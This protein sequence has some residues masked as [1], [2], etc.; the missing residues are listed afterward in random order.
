MSTQP[1][2]A[3][4]REQ[5]LADPDNLDLR[6]QYLVCRTRALRAQDERRA[7]LS[8]IAIGSLLGMA[9]LGLVGLVLGATMP[10]AVVV[11]VGSMHMETSAA[12]MKVHSHGAAAVS[13]GR[14]ASA[15]LAS[16]VGLLPIG[17]ILGGALGGLLAGSRFGHRLG[18]HGPR[19]WWGYCL[20]LRYPRDGQASGQFAPLEGVPAEVFLVHASNEAFLHRGSALLPGRT[21]WHASVVALQMGVVLLFAAV[22]LG[23]CTVLIPQHFLDEIWHLAPWPVVAGLV[24]VAMVLLIQARELHRQWWRCRRLERDGEVLFGQATACTVACANSVDDQSGCVSHGWQVDLHYEFTTPSGVVI[25]DKVR[26]TRGEMAE[27]QAPT[28]G[29]PVAV[30][31]VGEGL[32]Q[33]L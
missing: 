15:A 19:P 8:V 33:I 9:V 22:M 10:G 3:L 23:M 12:G 6:R 14:T 18:L 29:T 30:L 17:A 28:A 16:A 5:L 13:R 24:A 1:D 25:S 7:Q 11:S 21:P 4:L 2:P 26:F 20:P 31:Y 32:Y 27:E